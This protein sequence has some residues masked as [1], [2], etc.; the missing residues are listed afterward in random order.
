MNIW[1]ISD[2]HFNHK[3]ILKYENRPVDFNEVIINNWNSRVASEDIVIHLGDVIFGYDKETNLPPI[4]NRL[5]GK[6]VLARGNHDIPRDWKW[7][8]DKGF[9]FV[10]DYY[11]Y[12]GM[13]FSH[14]P[15]TPLPTQ[16]LNNH[17]K[18]IELNIHGHFHRGSHR[19]PDDNPGYVDEFY[20]F[21]YYKANQDKYK[22]IQIEDELR[23]F[24][25]EEILAR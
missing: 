24:S 2:T 15:L 19:N 21:Q 16:A 4:L 1:I 12:E 13:A 6:K 9:D 8:M 5:N 20:D 7:Y 11:V 17:S 3:N 10:C 25:L 22:L 18:P 14:A 23:P